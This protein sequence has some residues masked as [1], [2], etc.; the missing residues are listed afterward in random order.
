MAMPGSGQNYRSS[1]GGTFTD[2][3]L[4]ATD[5]PLP[6]GAAVA[7]AVQTTDQ[8]VAECCDWL[9]FHRVW[10]Q[11]PTAARQAIARYF[12]PEHPN[13]L[14][15]IYAYLPFTLAANLAHYI[16]AT[17]TEAGQILPV[18]ARTLG[19]RGTG[20]PTLVWSADVAAFL[21]GITLLSALVFSIY[22]LLRITKRPLLSNLL[23]LLFMPGF[24]VFLFKLML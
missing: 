18:T 7:S 11:L 5:Q 19:L 23:H 24:T 15:V 1:P 9:S 3:R 17:I 20:L 6:L 10:G 14:T 13:Y 2:L 16:P 4:T 8:T 22:P 21:Q 12:D